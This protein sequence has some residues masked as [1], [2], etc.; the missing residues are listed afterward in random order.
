MRRFTLVALASAALAGTAGAQTSVD[1]R[2]GPNGQLSGSASAG[3]STS[4]VSAGNG[5]VTAEDNR[6]GWS[7]QGAH[8]EAHCT[9]NGRTMTVTSP[10][11]SSSSS[12]STSGTGSG[13]VAGG[14]SPGSRVRTG[15]CDGPTDRA[16]GR[17]DAS[18]SYGPS[19]AGGTYAASSSSAGT[20]MAPHRAPVRHHRKRRVRR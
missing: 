10:D 3:A 19:R 2:T 11:G 13:T 1:I 8:S 4:S 9:G 14:G 7:G 12:V 15:E 16:Y 18:N 6:R 5:A 17:S 20:G